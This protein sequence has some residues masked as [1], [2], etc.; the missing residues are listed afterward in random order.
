MGMEKSSNRLRSGF[1]G[2]LADIMGYLRMWN[3]AVGGECG[4]LTTL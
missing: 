4:L 2:V 1:V 3:V